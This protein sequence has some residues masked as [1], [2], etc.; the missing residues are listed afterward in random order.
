MYPVEAICQMLCHPISTGLELFGTF[1]TL[2]LVCGWLNC[3]NTR[4]REIARRGNKVQ[5]SSSV[6]VVGGG[7]RGTRSEKRG[8]RYVAEPA[9]VSVVMPVKGCRPH[10]VS[11]WLSQVNMQY[12]GPLEF[13]FVVESEADPAYGALTELLRSEEWTGVSVLVAGQSTTCSQKIHNQLTGVAKANSAH[14]YLFFLDDD[15]QLHPTTLEDLVGTLE[16]DPSLFM[17]TGYPF[18]LVSADGS[19]FSHAIAAYHHILGIGATSTEQHMFIWGGCMLVPLKCI[20]EDGFGIKSAWRNGGYSDDLILVTTCKEYGLKTICPFYSVFPQRLHRCTYWDFWNYLHRQLFVMDTYRNRTGMLLNWTLL[21]L[22]ALLGV[23]MST[24]MLLSAIRAAMW[25]ASGQTSCCQSRLEYLPQV[26]LLL[27]LLA[28]L[29]FWRLLRIMATLFT[30]LSP[31]RDDGVPRLTLEYLLKFWAG[32]YL[33]WG[34]IAA[35]AAYT[36]CHSEIVWSGV[37]YRKHR[38]AVRRV[39]K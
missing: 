18:D 30:K 21:S 10:S 3:G 27:W 19:V 15:V 39:L 11:N 34:M 12:S 28:S 37:R 13:L 24:P 2:I 35:V 23:L 33:C 6:V 14:K 36:L 4:L 25:L 1:W 22:L 20:Q 31:N 7:G 9:G 8:G 17:A 29:A 38:G 16:G 26:W 32:F 5:Q